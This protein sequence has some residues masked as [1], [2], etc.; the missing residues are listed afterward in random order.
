MAQRNRFTRA[1]SRWGV[2]QKRD[3]ANDALEDR[4]R[5][6]NGG[7]K[8]VKLDIK[9]RKWAMGRGVNDVVSLFF[10]Y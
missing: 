3:G 10:L 6:D 2:V 8:G 4:E 7:R 1:G 5:D 9:A